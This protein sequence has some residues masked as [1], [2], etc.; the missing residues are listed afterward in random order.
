MAKVGDDEASDPGRTTALDLIAGGKVALVFNTPR[1]P[2]A[3][4][5][6]KPIRTA[7]ARHEIPCVTTTAAALAAAAGIADWAEHRLH[8]RSLQ[9]WHQGNQLRL[10]L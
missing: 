10:D 2:E 7:A 9:E 1:G 4:A 8:V 3:R 6:D 5:D